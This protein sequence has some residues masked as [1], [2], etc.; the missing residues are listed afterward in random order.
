MAIACRITP[1]V[2]NTNG[3]VRESNLHQDLGLFANKERRSVL[4][5]ASRRLSDI[6]KSQST[7]EGRAAAE[8]I[9]AEGHSINEVRFDENDEPLAED[10]LGYTKVGDVLSDTEIVTGL[11]ELH[12]DKVVR[13]NVAGDG[14]TI[15]RSS[16]NVN[17]VVGLRKWAKDFNRSSPLKER[18]Y[19]NVEYDKESHSLSLRFYPNSQAIVNATDRA[20]STAIANEEQAAEVDKQAT[21]EVTDKGAELE[22]RLEGWLEQS[23]IGIEFLSEAEAESGIDG[24]TDYS[25]TR[26]T[27]SGLAAIVRVSRGEKG[28]AAITE[29]AAHVAIG[30]LI[31]KD[32]NVDR[33]IEV[34][35]EHEELIKNILGEREYELYYK[36]YDG[37]MNKMAHEAA[38]HLL[39]EALEKE[40]AIDKKGIAKYKS[41]WSRMVDAV[42]SFFGRL[43]ESALD[44]ALRD[45]KT[46][47][48]KT[49]RDILDG[50]Y[51][52]TPNF[53]EEIKA[54]KSLF[55]IT[56]NQ[57]QQL[58]DVVRRMLAD[59]S[60]RMRRIPGWMR[61][62]KRSR[63]TGVPGDNYYEQLQS[64]I[65][66]MKDLSDKGK[67]LAAVEVYMRRAV[68]DLSYQLVTFERRFEK[69][70]SMVSKAYIL[71]NIDIQVKTFKQVLKVIGPL[72][73]DLNKTAE[74][75]E[76]KALLT[77]IYNEYQGFTDVST[78][79]YRPGLT[80]LLFSVN[81][82]VSKRKIPL[83]V[84]YVSK[85]IKLDNI[86]VPK[87]SKAYGKNGGEA[88][89]LAE[90]MMKSPVMGS[91]DHWLLG[92][93][94]SNV[95]PVQVFQRM[96]NIFKLKVR[97]E[98]IDYK[99]RLQE[100]TLELEE[101]G[102][103]NQEFM[104]ERKDG[105]LTGRYIEKD[106]EE[107][108]A[109]SNA[110]KHY[111]EEVL[112]IKA[113]L[114]SMLPPCM[115]DVLN[116]VKIRRDL[117]ERLKGDDRVMDILNDERKEMFN[118]VSDD[119]YI[120]RED[121]TLVDFDGNQIRVM[122][123]RFIKFAND[124]DSQN[125]SMD[126]ANTMTRYAQMCCN[127]SIM[128]RLMPVLELGRSI[129]AEGS[130][131]KARHDKDEEGNIR[132]V[133]SEK[134]RETSNSSTLDRIDDIMK[135]ELYGFRSENVEV[136][137]KGT[138]ISLTRI[139]Q[140]LMA[141][142]AWSQYM[143]SPGAAIQ[144]DITARIQ[145]LIGTA[146][147]K[148]FN[149]ADLMY[150]K[151]E[152]NKNL[153]DMLADAAKRVPDTK[154]SLFNELFNTMQKDHFNPFN[155][156]GA[157]RI[158][159]DDLYFMTTMGE[160]HANTIIALA[161]AHRVILKDAN[162][163]K[164]NLWDAL[165]V[166]DMAEKK[167]RDADKM[168]RNGMSIE[169]QIL[170]ED[171]TK[172]PEWTN[173]KNK[174][175][176]L[177]AGVTKEDGSEFTFKDTSGTSDVEKFS[178]KIM[179]CSHRFNGIYNPEDAAKWQR[180][181]GG[182]MLGMYRKWIAP[183]WYKRMNGMNYSLDNEEWS[184]GYYRTAFR[185]IFVNRICALYDK[186]LAAQLKGEEL[187]DWERKNLAIAAREMTVW[188][189]LLG[190]T[191]ILRADK[192]ERRSYAYN[193][194][195]YFTCRSLSEVGSMVPLG[196]ARE[197]ARMMQSPSAVL[198]TV[199]KLMAFPGAMADAAIGN[200]IGID[201][202]VKSGKYKGMSKLERA[203][204]NLPFVPAYRPWMAF[205]HPEDAVRFY[206]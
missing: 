77:L 89:D 204:V 140:K 28:R 1:R 73:D 14:K 8:N 23:G 123:I 200:I 71:N 34:L 98:W 11:N 29:E 103:S 24:V 15:T 66:N 162:G 61:K 39:K 62:N 9:M 182:Q 202:L 206:E 64:T 58:E 48:R 184:E 109:L 114:D 102:Y 26:R 127:Y 126:I 132:E 183:S 57:K 16:E 92:A 189:A 21:K 36:R 179:D 173:S 67:T 41:L 38:G 170:R 81:D 100:L 145:S 60:T 55:A 198:P 33:A 52:S 110:Q 3:N 168:E 154:I 87:G 83:F 50:S 18:V 125:M 141:L 68:E 156:K 129:I 20:D 163:N 12:S 70:K 175:L 93:S 22:D 6:K 96:L 30:S 180:Y 134:T 44:S 142:T 69:S 128:G 197:T 47:M 80:Q 104:F 65:E 108:R 116:S 2:R 161:M 32:R 19:A 17:A 84:E 107:Y 159:T 63:R 135:S 195:Y 185:V 166:V 171:I 45:A 138:T 95:F 13:L 118:V 203:A 31:G 97:E 105:K 90:Q 54:M 157:S 124:E 160:Y 150:A 37:D 76:D 151:G 139:G 133:V 148:Y 181:I 25:S 165:E 199:T 164:M 86:I 143:L 106:S 136:D 75:A 130:D 174:Y 5:D 35:R 152:F 186:N 191:T 99:K 111:Y 131:T 172:H 177:R 53:S 79:E 167:R 113:E 56:E 40:D 190:L 178:R 205:L 144:N 192:K 74:S 120:M 193:L 137:V 46:T 112:A 153:F 43:N 27:A 94:L 101:A 59:T 119:E 158:H 194:L 117:M 196:I 149:T 188:A 146:D 201:D 4:W 85:F 155:H 49:A 78:G 147:A 122:P 176:V 91:I 88:V 82:K 121:K 10:L 42:K 51:Y 169:A 115:R 187:S 72:L 7:S